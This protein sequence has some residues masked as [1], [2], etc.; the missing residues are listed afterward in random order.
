MT[1]KDRNATPK[2]RG[3]DAVGSIIKRY[4]KR[5][6]QHAYGLRI[7]ADGERYWIP[8]GTEREGWNDVRA[9]DRRDEIT[10]LIRR[11]A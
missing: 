2:R 6:G 10:A 8:L 4:R 11:G 3:P 9:A 1:E 5:D 7:R